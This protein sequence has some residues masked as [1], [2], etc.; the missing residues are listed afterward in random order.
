MNFL[1]HPFLNKYGGAE[2][3]T[4]LLIRECKTKGIDAKVLTWKYEKELIKNEICE[5]C[6]N[7]IN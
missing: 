3:K 2:R 6:D 5:R 4:L 7:A 1:I